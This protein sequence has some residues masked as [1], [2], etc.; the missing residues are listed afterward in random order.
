MIEGLLY[1]RFR[2][3][4]DTNTIG[5]IERILTWT[6]VSVP[7]VIN[8]NRTIRPVYSNIKFAAPHEKL[9]LTP[10]DTP[11][12]TPR[13][14]AWNEVFSVAPAH[15]FQIE[16]DAL[17]DELLKTLDM[18]IVSSR[19]TK[20]IRTA[21]ANNP[22]IQAISSGQGGALPVL[23]VGSSLSADDVVAVGD[24]DI[25]S[26][27]IREAWTTALS[28]YAQQL[29]VDCI[30]TMKK[31]RLIVDEASA[32]SAITA[33]IRANEIETRQ[34]VAAWLGLDFVSMI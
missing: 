30:D 18:N 32:T 26:Q 11:I 28:I 31:E 14:Y 16:L 5:D 24:G 22:T 27:S 8:G 1:R 6:G 2:W 33:L 34:R 4:G 17:Q 21:D 23:E 29:G 7:V 15:R 13:E 19:M 9:T 10:I 3:E 25:K 20:Y 12:D